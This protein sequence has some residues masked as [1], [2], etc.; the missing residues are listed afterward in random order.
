MCFF[1]LLV[2]YMK[3]HIVFVF[4]FCISYLMFFSPF[5]HPWIGPTLLV[6]FLF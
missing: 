4:N 1:F 2:F 5:S 3:I 6:D